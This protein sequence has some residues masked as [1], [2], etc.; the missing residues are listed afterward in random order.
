MD[1]D[2]LPPQ[3]KDNSDEGFFGA[4]GWTFSGFAFV[5]IFFVIIGA[6]LYAAM[7]WFG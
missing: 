6:I 4:L 3:P 5:A 2:D 1:D 7:R